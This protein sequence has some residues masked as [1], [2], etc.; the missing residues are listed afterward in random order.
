MNYKEFIASGILEYYVLGL[1]TLAEKAEVEAYIE[2]YPEVKLEIDSIREAL[3]Q[4][5]VQSQKTPDPKLKDKIFLHIRELEKEEK[6][7]LNNNSKTLNLLK[8]KPE[9]HFN[10]WAAAAV[11]LL[12]LSSAINILIYYKWKNVESE[13]ALLTNEKEILASQFK[14]EKARF[15]Q[16][17]IEMDI[18][19]H[20][21]NKSIQLKGS[22]IDPSAMAVVYWNSENHELYLNIYKLPETPK[23]MQYQLWAIVNGK[24][25]DAGMLDSVDD[26]GVLHKMK[27]FDVAEAFAITLEKKGGSSVPNL[28]ALYVIG[29]V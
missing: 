2:K 27:N 15:T 11:S 17:A 3:D 24:P 6:A 4:L 10:W 29:N 18:L 14:I 23:G 13:L 20:P 28:E 22:K 21:A 19:K 9:K 16:S 5:A 7:K 8:L 25:V 26:L 12:I 1:T